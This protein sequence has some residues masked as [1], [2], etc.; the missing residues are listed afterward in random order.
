[1]FDHLLYIRYFLMLDVCTKI[2]EEDS[3]ISR[4]EYQSIKRKNCEQNA[5]KVSRRQARNF[6]RYPE[7][8]R[9]HIKYQIA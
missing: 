7:K 4:S 2:L 9:S 8:N 5:T 1:M 6:K 3:N